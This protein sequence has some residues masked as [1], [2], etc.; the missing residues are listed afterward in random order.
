MNFLPIRFRAV[1][2]SVLLCFGSPLLTSAATNYVAFGNFYFS[3]SVLTIQV[4]DTVIWTNAGG[5]HTVTGLTT[6]EPLC[7]PAQGVQACTNTFHVP[8]IFPY[9]CNIHYLYGMTGV[10][11]VVGAP[12]SSA[13]LT[14]AVWTN[15]GFVFTALT[16]PNQ[17]N[18]VQATTNL[19]VASNWV[20]LET[21]VPAG[22]VLRFTDTNASQF[23]GRFYRVVEP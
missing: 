22:D 19:A 1:V 13:V 12:L 17:T 21:N 7:G 11:N 5:F 6:N 23:P 14:N 18:I 10:V 16:T 20:S 9:Q 3:P 2:E 15:G 8:G 4:G